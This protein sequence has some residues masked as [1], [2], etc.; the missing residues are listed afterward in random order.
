MS[1]KLLCEMT[2][3]ELC[4]EYATWKQVY[5]MAEMSDSNHAVAGQQTRA[6]DK[7]AEVLKEFERRLW[8]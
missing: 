8:G 1:D 5:R 3:K 6:A 7:M 2:I 4:D